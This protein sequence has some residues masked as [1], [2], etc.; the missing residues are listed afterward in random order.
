M[1]LNQMLLL[2]CRP[3]E[4]LDA[5]TVWDIL[6]SNIVPNIVSIQT[7][8][9]PILSL[10]VCWSHGDSYKTAEPIEMPFGRWVGVVCP[11]SRN[12]E[13][14][15]VHMGA[16]GTYDGMTHAGRKQGLSLPL[17]KQLVKNM[18]V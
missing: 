4:G 11:F 10:P 9:V 3:V 17:L 2:T 15:G 5:D 13:L 18:M 16:P 14:D 12:H 6:T 8:Q 1:A 7:F